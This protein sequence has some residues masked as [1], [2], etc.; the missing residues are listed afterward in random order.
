MSRIRL[1]ALLAAILDGGIN[2]DPMWIQFPMFF[3]SSGLSTKNILYK[4]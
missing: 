2:V 1:C 4:I 3:M